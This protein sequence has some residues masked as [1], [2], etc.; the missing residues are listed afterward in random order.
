M[1]WLQNPQSTYVLAAYGVAAVGLL[2]LLAAS[3]FALRCRLREWHK[4]QDKRAK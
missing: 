3:L 4:I 1:T 2:G